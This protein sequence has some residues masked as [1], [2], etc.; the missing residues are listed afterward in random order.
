LVSF[1]QQET[2]SAHILKE[3]IHQ[4]YHNQ[5]SHALT[6][7]KKV[8]KTDADNLASQFGVSLHR[9]S[10]CHA[11]QQ[12]FHNLVK[13][14]SKVLSGVKGLGATKV[15]S[16]VDAFNKPFMVGGLKRSDGTVRPASDLTAEKEVSTSNRVDQQEAAAGPSRKGNGH[17]EEDE[18]AIG[19]PD[20]PSDVDEDEEGQEAERTIGRGREKVPSRSPP[21]IAMEENAIW[22][23]P[24]DD[25]DGDGDEAD[26]PP[27]KRRRDS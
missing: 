13:Q 26:G 8:N 14:P 12:S 15:N 7:G 19:S 6:S 21:P 17:A 24:L 18:E 3:K 9:S 23:D 27:T 20:W 10:K 22:Q 4:S 5:L 2:S 25:D 11:K 16:L 1:K